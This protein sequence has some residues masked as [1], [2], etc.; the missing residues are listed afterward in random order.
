MANKFLLTGFIDYRLVS[1][2]RISSK[3][4]RRQENQNLKGSVADQQCFD[5]DPKADKT[6]D[7]DAH[8]NPDKAPKLTAKLDQ[9][10]N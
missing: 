9:V 6:F 4:T 10:S 3:H 2:K 7:F 5:V 8:M 1:F